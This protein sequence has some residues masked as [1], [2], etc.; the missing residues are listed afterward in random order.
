MPVW[1]RKTYRRGDTQANQKVKGTV[2]AY[3]RALRLF[4]KCCKKTDP[5]AIDRDDLKAFM[6][7]LRA[8]GNGEA[9]VKKPV[10][11]CTDFLAGRRCSGPFAFAL[12]KWKSLPRP[13][14]KKP[15]TYTDEKWAAML[16]NAT[17]DESD[18]LHFLEGMGTRGGEAK[19]APWSR[20]DL[21]LGQY[22]VAE[23][24][25][26]HTIDRHINRVISCL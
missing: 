18:L 17:L 7:C 25:G 24:A 5:Q 8:R 4:Q 12:K 3:G 10:E 13:A 15:T 16:F 9:T 26:W 20:L 21:N 22:L 1:T 19:H 11:S 23:C 6:A 2:T 14:K